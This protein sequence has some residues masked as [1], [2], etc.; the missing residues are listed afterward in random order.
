VK[1]KSRIVKH[2]SV[3]HLYIDEVTRIFYF[4]V[5]DTKLK[6]SITQSLG[7]KDE[8]KAIRGL[9][10]AIRNSE[11]KERKVEN[12]LVKDYYS[13][14]L[15]KEKER[16]LAEATRIQNELNWRL[17][18]EPFWGNVSDTEINQDKFSE[19]LSW[20]KRTKGVKV[21]NA[22]KVIRKL[23]RY[24]KNK[25]VN[26]SVD[27]Y[28]PKD[29]VDDSNEEK[30]N[31][32]SKEEFARFI[33]ADVRSDFILFF[34]LA[35]TFG[36]RIGELTNLRKNRIVEL[37]THVEVHLRKSDTKNRKARE[38]P[39]TKPLS[40]RMR[41]QIRSSPGEYVFPAERNQAKPVSKQ[42]VERAIKKCAEHAGIDRNV[43]SHDF[44]KSAATNMANLE[45][46]PVKACA[47]LGMTLKIYMGIYVKKQNLNLSSV[48]DQLSKFMGDL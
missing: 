1:Q 7:T 19:F 40:Q 48:T 30:G 5:Y 21:A 9:V 24:M 13:G 34:E 16:R 31:Y 17:H 23:F 41:D 28:I 33:R 26:T 46:D 20:H 8:K 14:F 29:E 15:A 39:F 10:S 38:I 36:F 3:P 32:M 2:G 47:M 25:G 44:R 22:L 4:R 11:P 35:Y 12:T 42:V 27:I 45:V 6:N 18:V 37:G 43:T